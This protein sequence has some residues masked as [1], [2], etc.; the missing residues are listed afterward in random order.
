MS[1]GLVTSYLIKQCQILEDVN[2][3]IGCTDFCS[4]FKL[5]I[6]RRVSKEGTWRYMIMKIR[7]PQD[8]HL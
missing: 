1:C 4:N 5:W 8:T 6:L 2:L 3:H 7:G